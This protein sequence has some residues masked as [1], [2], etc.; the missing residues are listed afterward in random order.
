MYATEVSR[1]IS[2]PPAAV[3]RALLDARA[4]AGWRVP[5]GMTCRVHEFDVRVGGAFRVSLTYDDGRPGAGKSADRTDTYQG[6]FAELVP[7]EKVVEVLRFET[8]DVRF[9]GTMTLTTTLVPTGRGTTVVLLH[10]GVPD[11]VPAAANEVGTRRALANLAR[12]VEAETEAEAEAET[13]AETEGD[14]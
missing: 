2:A 9:A 13:E 5:D 8:D 14:R 1:Y 7:F 12:W 6:R 11:A 3:Y 4:V 10:E